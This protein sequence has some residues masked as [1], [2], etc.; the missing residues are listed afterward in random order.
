VRQVAVVGLAPST[1]DQAPFDDP[2]WETW[3]LAQDNEGYPYLDRAFEIHPL[4][5]IR[6]IRRPSFEDRLKEFDVPLYMQEAYP[7]I[8]NA[9]R[10]PLEE[11]SSVVGDYFNSSISYMLGL[12]IVEKVDHIGIWGVDMDGEDEFAYQRPNAEYMIGFARGV[13]ISI[14]T[15]EE[16][17]LLTYGVKGGGIHTVNWKGRYGYFGEENGK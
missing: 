11:V 7:E 2:D 1:H 10:Y 4:D 5:F 17:A 13:G 9:V 14:Y 15:P 16:S 6:E 8:P 3:G 12:A